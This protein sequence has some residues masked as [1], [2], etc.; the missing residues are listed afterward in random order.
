MAADQ[1]MYEILGVMDPF[2]FISIPCF[3]CYLFG[4]WNFVLLSGSLLL[5]LSFSPFYINI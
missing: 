2:R 5:F 4:V 1:S 3:A